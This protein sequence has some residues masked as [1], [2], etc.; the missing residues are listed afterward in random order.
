MS[1]LH[2]FG[3][4]FLV[5]VNAF[6]SATEFSLVAVRDSRVRQLIEKG[7]PRAKIVGELIADL[8]RVVSGVQVGITICSLLLGYLGETTLATVLMPMAS[9]FQSPIA[10]I[11]AHTIALAIAF[12]LLTVLQVVLGELVPKSLS[13]ARAERV[14]LLVARPFHWFLRTFRWAID[15]LD[16]T[17]ET[18]TRALGVTSHQSHT[19]LRSSEELQVMLQQ[20][21]D[22]GFIPATEVEFIQNAMEL[23]QIQVREIMVPRPDMHALPV[24]AT[25]D[26]TMKLFAATQRSRVPV[27]EG[28]LD[29]ILGFVHIKDVVW[30]LLDIARAT[31]DD[32]AATTEFHLRNML[33]EVLIVPETKPASELLLEFRAKRVG[34][35]MIV[36]EFGSILGLTTLEDILE[37]M[38]GEIHDE[39]DVVEGPHVLPEGELLF[40]GAIAVR[41]L[42]TQY[43][44]AL[45][46]DPAYETLGGFT[47]NRLGF[48]PRGGESFEAE[49][50]RFT[51]M[52]MDHRRVARVKIKPLRPAALD[53]QEHDHRAAGNA[54]QTKGSP[55]TGAREAS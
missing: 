3:V 39:F 28:S 21:R 22:R 30:V 14:A 12:G 16:N 50:Y 25:L 33:R 26:E 48:I 52:E 4:L 42:E 35:A 15:L 18:L 24:D 45:P 10:A 51:V 1:A 43:N 8:N 46:E 53:Q 20:A 38:V 32:G 27:Y 47:L 31:P 36:D 7:D 34:L 5:G 41:E 29:H 9:S 13:L 40:D 2:L 55:R 44:I 23:N 11:V 37:Q 49:G 19:M 6:F 17:A 54:I